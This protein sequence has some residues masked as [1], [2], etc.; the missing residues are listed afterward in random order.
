MDAG[1]VSPRTTAAWPDTT[2]VY[3]A[4]HYRILI[5][6]HAGLGRRRR[7]LSRPRYRSHGFAIAHPIIIY[8]NEAQ[9]FRFTNLY[10]IAAVT[11]P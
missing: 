3:Y 5:A 8:C 2:A 11:Q 4:R 10:L 6:Q 9:A 7:L 1:Y